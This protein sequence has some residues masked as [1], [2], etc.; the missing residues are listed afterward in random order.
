MKVNYVYEMADK[1][2]CVKSFFQPGPF[3]L[4]VTIRCLLHASSRIWTWTKTKF[5][6]GCMMLEPLEQVPYYKNV[7][8]SSVMKILNNPSIIKKV[9]GGEGSMWYFLSVVKPS[10]IYLFK[11]NSG[12]TKTVCEICSKILVLPLLALHMK[13]RLGNIIFSSR[14]YKLCINF[15]SDQHICSISPRKW[16][17]LANAT[18]AWYLIF[19]YITFLEHSTL[20]VRIKPKISKMK[21]VLTVCYYHVTCEFQ[22]ESSLASLAKWLSVRLWLWLRIS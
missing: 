17:L 13:F 10:G 20:F 11:V 3:S 7:L 5:W 21:I 2:K 18:F 15:A 8:N 19:W 22:S 6:L 4:V 16:I 14:I 9:F 12:N 1:W